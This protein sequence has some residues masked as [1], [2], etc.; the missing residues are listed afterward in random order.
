MNATEAWR[1]LE[2]SVDRTLLATMASEIGLEDAIAAAARMLAG[3]QTGR[4]V[5]TVTR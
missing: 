5:V 1:R 2:A 4:L 3:R